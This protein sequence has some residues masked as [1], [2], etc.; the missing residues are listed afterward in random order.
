MDRHMNCDGAEATRLIARQLPDVRVVVLTGFS[1]DDPVFAALR[2]GARG[3]LTKD[4]GEVL[5]GDGGPR[6]RGPAGPVSAA[7]AG[8]GHGQG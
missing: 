5:H 7:Q 2:A 6:G 3:F 4:A 1:H 8:L